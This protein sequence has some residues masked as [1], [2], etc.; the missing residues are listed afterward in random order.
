MLTAM[1]FVSMISCDFNVFE[2][3]PWAV[4]ISPEL[5]I[6]QDRLAL[7]GRAFRRRGERLKM[8]FSDKTC[9][10]SLIGENV[11]EGRHVFR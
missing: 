3:V 6:S 9:R 11:S 4:K 10:I 1:R 8:G 5:K 7:Q 2:T